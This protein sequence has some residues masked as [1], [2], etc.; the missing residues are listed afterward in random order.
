MSLRKGQKLC[1]YIVGQGHPNQLVHLKLFYMSD[2][3][4]DKVLK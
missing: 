3:E 1:N 4:F 2:E